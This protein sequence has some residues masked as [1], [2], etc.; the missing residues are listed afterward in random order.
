MIGFIFDKIIE[1][2]GIQGALELNE[3]YY[4]EIK[5]IE[6]EWWHYRCLGNLQTICI[7]YLVN[8]IIYEKLKAGNFKLAI[9]ELWQK[10]AFGDNLIISFCASNVKNNLFV[11]WFKE[12]LNDCKL[13][14]GIKRICWYNNKRERWVEKE[15]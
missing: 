9:I 15:V 5:A 10:K 8:D 6:N 1:L 11:K 4:W 3:F 2:G 7:F 13:K 14:F 12:F